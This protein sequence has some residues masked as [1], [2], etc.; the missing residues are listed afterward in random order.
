MTENLGTRGTPEPGM[1]ILPPQKTNLEDEQSY[2]RIKNTNTNV[3]E[4]R[5]ESQRLQEAANRIAKAG[6]Q[7]MLQR[8]RLIS[9]CLGIA[10][11]A[12]VIKI[13]EELYKSEFH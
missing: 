11:E 6:K 8:A 7:K 4:L 9:I 1:A 12:F 3:V 5:K 2:A 13:D 10:G